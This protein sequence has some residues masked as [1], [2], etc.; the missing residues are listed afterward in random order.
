MRAVSDIG[1]DIKSNS[2][3]RA[4]R[5]GACRLCIFGSWHSQNI[6]DGLNTNRALVHVAVVPLPCS[7]SRPFANKSVPFA[8][9]H[10][11]MH[12]LEKKYR[13]SSSHSNRATVPQT[14]VSKPAYS[15]SIT[16]LWQCQVTMRCPTSQGTYSMQGLLRHRLVA[17]VPATQVPQ[18]I[19]LAHEVFCVLSGA[20][21]EAIRRPRSSIASLPAL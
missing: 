9:L 14:V 13:R 18:A 17:H 4:V 15:E 20:G 12:Y 3:I 19:G 16:S 1:L 7:L 6:T 10:P 8:Q 11:C 21:M 5:S 2:H